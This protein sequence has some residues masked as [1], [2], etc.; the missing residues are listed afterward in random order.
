MTKYPSMPRQLMMGDRRPSERT[1]PPEQQVDF[2]FHDAE[3]W[4]EVLHGEISFFTAGGVKYPLVRGEALKIPQGEVHRVEIAPEGVTYQMWVLD[5]SGKPF[6]SHMLDD[7]DIS[8]ISKNLEL[9]EIENRWDRRNEEGV[10]P[11]ENEKNRALL[12]AL[13]SEELTFCNAAGMVLRKKDYMDRAPG[14]RRTSSDG[15]RILYKN[16][17][18]ML[19]ATTVHAQS[20]EGSRKSFSN[21]RLF[22][23]E[24]DVWRCRVW[25]NHPD[26]GAS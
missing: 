16:P 24:E 22:V 19:L 8:L 6:E 10:S 21:Y 15:I 17:K 11:T 14:D 18:S 26:P 9:P 3:E 25:M 23:K 5:N 13:L 4:L 12:D 2:H 1:H 7:E 20:K